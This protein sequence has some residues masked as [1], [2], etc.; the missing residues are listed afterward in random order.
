[1]KLNTEKPAVGQSG[2]FAQQGKMLDNLLRKLQKTILCLHRGLLIILL[3]CHDQVA[4][5]MMKMLM[6]FLKQTK[7]FCLAQS[8]SLTG[9]H[10]LPE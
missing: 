6:T 2:F 9:R 8:V 10:P 5:S 1:M 7:G 3:Q 4:G